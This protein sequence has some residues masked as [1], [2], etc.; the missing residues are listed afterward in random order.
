MTFGAFGQ[1][2][3]NVKLTGD[4]RDLQGELRKADGDLASFSKSTKALLT[5][6]AFLGVGAAVASFGA[7]AVAEADRVADATERLNIQLGDVSDTLIDTADDF[8]HLGQSAQDMLE[9]EA[10]AAD[11]LTGF[12]VADEVIANTADDIAATAAAIELLGGAETTTNIDLITRAAGGAEK[13][14]RELGVWVSDADAKARAMADTGKDNADA[15]TDGEIAAG[16]LAEI[17]EQLA[18]KLDA[19]KNGQQDVEQTS[20]ELQARWETLTGQIGD[21]IDGPLNDFLGWALDGVEGIGALADA[22][23]NASTQ[24][25][26]LL[27]LLAGLGSFVNPSV[28]FGIDQLTAPRGGGGGGFS[29]QVVGAPGRGSAP[30]VVQVQDGAPDATERAVVDAI[31]THQR[32]NGREIR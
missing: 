6:A 17:L 16:R 15:L 32:Q 29:G 13:S 21:A 9:L 8:S 20:K 23:G 3:V 22:I 24:V 12:G 5:G 28:G 31:R 11:V 4:R 19:V 2:E 14:M 10:R 18:P 1:G 25:E 26:G 30:V 27:A 7:D